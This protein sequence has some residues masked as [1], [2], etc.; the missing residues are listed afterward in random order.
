MKQRI[1]IACG[2]FVLGITALSTVANAAAGASPNW[3]YQLQ[4]AAQLNADAVRVQDAQ[5]ARQQQQRL[6]QDSGTGQQQQ[7][8]QQHRQQLQRGQSPMY[9]GGASSGRGQPMTAGR[10]GGSGRR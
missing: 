1:L 8:R 2:T 4:H 9:G 7:Y 3:Q 6:L 5:Q 10:S